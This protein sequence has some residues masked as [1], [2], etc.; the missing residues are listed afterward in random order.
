MRCAECRHWRQSLLEPVD[1]AQPSHHRCFLAMAIPALLVLLIWVVFA[2]SLAVPDG[3][4]WLGIYPRTVSGLV[5]IALGPLI[6]ANLQHAVAN[7][8]PLLVLGTFLFYFYP[9]QA[10]RVLAIVWLCAGIGTW[11]IGRPSY[12]VGASG[13]LYGI[14]AYLVVAGWTTRQRG[15]AA[16]ALLVI[17][18]Y[19][20]WIWG[21]LP[22]D[23]SISWEG[24]LC[25]ALTGLVLGLL[26]RN[27]LPGN[28]TS[29]SSPHIF[30]FVNHS[31]NRHVRITYF[32]R[33]PLWE[34]GG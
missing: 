26:H 29:S 17:F 24:H 11:I 7:S 33:V 12:H 9:N 19:G 22:N 16:I 13:L 27:R 15:L 4:F 20:S 6:H 30:H 14:A 8:V 3:F 23:P 28:G 32:C 2:W 1:K 5:G 34:Y 10:L 21:I 25:G 31:G 18:L